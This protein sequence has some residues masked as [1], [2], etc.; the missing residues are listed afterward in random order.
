MEVAA[1]AG[2]GGGMTTMMTTMTTTTTRMTTTMTTTTVI[3]NRRLGASFLYPELNANATIGVTTMRAVVNTANERVNPSV[4]DLSNW[5]GGEVGA[6][7]AML[8]P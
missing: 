1:A 3:K 7:I 8:L 4:M 5:S 2:G 6:T